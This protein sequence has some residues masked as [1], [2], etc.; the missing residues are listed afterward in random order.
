[1]G[2]DLGTPAAVR[3]PATPGLWR[4]VTTSENKLLKG[5]QKAPPPKDLLQPLAW[6]MAM[7]GGGGFGMAAG[8]IAVCSWR[9]PWASRHLPLPFP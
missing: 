6:G 3:R 9:R 2:V 4:A 8:G 1:M 5:P 7:R